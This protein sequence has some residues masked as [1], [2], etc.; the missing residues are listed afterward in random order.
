MLFIL[1][2]CIQRHFSNQNNEIRKTMQPI[3][4]VTEATI[5]HMVELTITKKIADIRNNIQPI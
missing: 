1:H 4:K 5:S 3:R 2:L